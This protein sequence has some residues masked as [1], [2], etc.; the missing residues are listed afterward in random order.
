[1]R[2]GPCGPCMLALAWAWAAVLLLTLGIAGGMVV[3]GV[4]VQVPGDPRCLLS[5]DYISQQESDRR[6]TARPIHH[7][8]KFRSQTTE[9]RGNDLFYARSFT[10]VLP[11]SLNLL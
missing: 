6:D 10:N 5:A 3:L 1:M 4:D 11:T 9:V 8:L 2:N 7:D